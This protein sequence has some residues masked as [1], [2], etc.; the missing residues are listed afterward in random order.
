MAANKRLDELLDERASD[1]K[2]VIQ[3]GAGLRLST[4]NTPPITEVEDNAN[5][6]STKKLDSDNT[7]SQT[8]ETVKSQKNRDSD[9]YVRKASG[10]KLRVDLTSKLKAY[11]SLQGKPF[12]VALEEAIAEYLEKHKGEVPY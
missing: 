9:N 1:P 5:A 4:S 6:A 2:P 11:A 3:R 10:Y 7:K 8:N 12:Q